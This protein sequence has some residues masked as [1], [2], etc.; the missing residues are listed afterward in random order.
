LPPLPSL[1]EA[2]EAARRHAI[3]EFPP[4]EDG[5]PEDAGATEAAIEVSRSR[6][7]AVMDPEASQGGSGTGPTPWPEPRAVAVAAGSGA[8]DAA[9]STLLLR[10]TAAS[11]PFDRVGEV[12]APSA[13]EPQPRD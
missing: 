3:G 4:I 2:A 6:L 8:T 13:E 11:R 1:S 12:A 10:T 9:G 7:M 5:T